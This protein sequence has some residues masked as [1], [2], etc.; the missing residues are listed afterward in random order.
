MNLKSGPLQKMFRQTHFIS[1]P[2]ILPYQSLISPHTLV[3]LSKKRGM[4]KKKEE[5]W[6]SRG[7]GEG[8]KLKKFR[9]IF[10]KYSY[11]FFELQILP[12]L[13]AWG[14]TMKGNVIPEG[15]VCALTNDANSSLVFTYLGL[16][17]LPRT[18]TNGKS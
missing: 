15:L 1:S 14:E 7:N 2:Q 12:T 9:T 11:S 4:K 18:E 6:Y 16:S 5:G 17:Y 3:V 8:Y 13:L 10:L